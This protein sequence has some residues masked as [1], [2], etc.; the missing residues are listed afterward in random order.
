MD[1]QLILHTEDERKSMLKDVFLEEI[2]EVVMQEKF[3]G[4]YDWF[5]VE[6]DNHMNIYRFSSEL[7]SKT[8]NGLGMTDYE[9]YNLLYY[10]HGYKDKKILKRECCYELVRKFYKTNYKST[11]KIEIDNSDIDIEYEYN[12]SEI[13]VFDDFYKNITNWGELKWGKH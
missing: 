8:R 11:G 10:I 3:P 2:P 6:E 13:F 4:Y 1:A 7:L 5:A 12:I 9:Y